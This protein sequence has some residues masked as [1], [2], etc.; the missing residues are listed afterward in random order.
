MKAVERFSSNRP[1]EIKYRHSRAI[2]AGP[3]FK[4][5]LTSPSDPAG[6]IVGVGDIR[7][8]TRCCLMIIHDM[9][10]RAGMSF[11]HV[12]ATNVY[13]LD[14]R[15][16]E[17]AAE[18]HCELLAESRPVLSFIGVANFWHPEILVEVEITA[19]D[20]DRASPGE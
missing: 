9:L 10:A 5:C 8:Q 3:L 11:D 12:I 15:Q 16:F 1:W 4:T 6:G 14:T 18:V 2:L 13:M 7:E 19:Y 17:A 20:A